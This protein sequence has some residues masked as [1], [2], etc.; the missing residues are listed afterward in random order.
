ML[1]VP[2]IGGRNNTKETN[3]NLASKSSLCLAG[4]DLLT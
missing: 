3:H 4:L 2:N 1:L